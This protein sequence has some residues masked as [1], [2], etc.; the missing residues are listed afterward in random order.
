MSKRRVP[1]RLHRFVLRLAILALRP[2]EW[3][4]LGLAEGA[5]WFANL[6]PDPKEYR[7]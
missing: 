1:I 6:F 3:F 4:T 2:V 7:R 5:T